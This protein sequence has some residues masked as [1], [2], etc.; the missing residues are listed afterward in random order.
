MND[1]PRRL[2]DVLLNPSRLWALLVE[3]F[4]LQRWRRLQAISSPDD[5][6]QFLNSRASFGAQ[7]SLYGYLR[8]RAGMRYPELFDDDHFV[9]SIN[10]AK[11]H[12]WLAC[13]SDIAVYAGGLLVQHPHAAE[14][15]VHELIQNVVSTILDETGI[16]DEAGHE[17]TSHRERVQNRIA[18]CNW[19]TIT[20]DEMPFT[21]SP[22]ALVHWAPI[23]DSIKQLDEDIVTNSVRFRWQKVRRDLRRALNPELV[24]GFR[25]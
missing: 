17:F 10:I 18:T 24:L 2:I 22:P 8:T 16:P 1:E 13:L 15:K 4:G 6:K 20:D 25:G 19:K 21:E 5:L 11:W 9:V 23:I 12:I 14:E 7:T 3:Y